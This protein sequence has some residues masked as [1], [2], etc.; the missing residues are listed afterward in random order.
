M[1]SGLISILI[2]A[3]E[4]HGF[5]SKFLEFSLN[6]IKNQTY[7]NV[8]V[9]VGDQS[10]NSKIKE[11]CE[12]WSSEINIRWL[13]NEPELKCSSTN[14]NYIAK[15]I[16]NDSKFI[17]ILFQDDFLYD[18]MSLEYTVNAFNLNHELKW[19]ASSCC[20]S[21]TGLDKYYYMTPYYYDKIYLAEPNSISSPSVI[22]IRSDCYIDF[23]ER[24]MWLMD[25]DYYKQLFDKYGLPIILDKT[26]CINRTWGSQVSN[27]L[28]DEI[29]N[30]EVNYIKQ[31][32]ER[33]T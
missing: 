28:S 11:L 29:K 24:L 19:L 15:H 1:D 16:N 25:V 22:S 8:E 26:T 2:P 4:M 21:K 5:G 12:K 32:Y 27:M 20:H 17:K 9:L 18:E 6:I 33:N 3:Y 30:S 31:K 23:D 13:K 7:K 14:L 10:V